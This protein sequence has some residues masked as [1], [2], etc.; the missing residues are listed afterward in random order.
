[1]LCCSAQGTHDAGGDG[2]LLGAALVAADVTGTE[3]KLWRQELTGRKEPKNP[4]S[5]RVLRVNEDRRIMICDCEFQ[6]RVV[7]DEFAE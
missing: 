7:G 4:A 3:S 2:L 5:S 1:M 6:F